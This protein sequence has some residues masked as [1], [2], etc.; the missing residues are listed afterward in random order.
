MLACCRV[1]GGHA[2]SGK[3][4][5]PRVDV[6]PHDKALRRLMVEHPRPLHHLAGV[7][8]SMLPC[9]QRQACAEESILSSR[10]LCCVGPQHAS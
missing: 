2:A 7:Q 8:V 1:A 9:W 4:I 6:H 10:C 3:L 5:V